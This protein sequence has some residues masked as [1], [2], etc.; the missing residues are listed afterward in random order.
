MSPVRIVIGTILALSLAGN[1][2]LGRAWLGQRDKATVAV[3]EER[4]AVGV[5][6][7]C[8]KGT[9]KL[10]AAADQRHAAAAPLIATA[11]D[12]AKDL[13]RQADQIMTTPPAVPGNACASAQAQLDD[14]W[15]KRK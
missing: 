12:K 3:V 6:L 13:D 14:W 1:A 11:K 2:W 15:E 10:D 4:Q 5:A 7:E 9:E 8:S